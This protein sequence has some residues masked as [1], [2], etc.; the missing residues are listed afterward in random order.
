MNP[1]TSDQILEDDARA[2]EADSSLGEQLRRARE[3]RGISLRDISELTRITMRHLEA[4]EQDDYKYL[5]GGIFNR[6]F[7]K[8]YA[9]HVKFNEHR[10]LELYAVAA[11]E[12]GEAMDDP[13]TTPQ[14][15][16]IY[17]EIDASRTPLMTFLLSAAIIALLI[18]IVYA[19]LHWYR[20]TENPT[21]AGVTTTT[22]TAPA[23]ASNATPNNQPT[24]PTASQQTAAT[25]NATDFQIQ[26][27]AKD[28]S[29]WLTTLQDD[30]KKKKGRQLFPDKPEDFAPASSLDLMFDKPAAQFLEVSING[31]PA[32]LPEDAAS[33]GKWKITKDNY[34]QFLP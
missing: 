31:R 5:P 28:K 24:A 13:L 29:F 2:G 27:K 12:H 15:S 14:R 32:R 25:M 18:L 34:K 20:R 19:G 33:A 16:R 17:T 8:A 23:A 9:R 6:S 21:Q 1:Q 26:V 22:T 30:E 11:R 3:A 4:I 7:I 10:A